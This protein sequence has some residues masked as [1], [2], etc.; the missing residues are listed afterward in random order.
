MGKCQ[1]GMGGQFGNSFLELFTVRLSHSAQQCNKI[2][3]IVDRTHPVLE[4]G[5]GVVV[6]GELAIG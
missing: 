3:N 2:V 4:L 1:M 6:L 5:L